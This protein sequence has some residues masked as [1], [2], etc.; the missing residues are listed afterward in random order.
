ME[1]NVGLLLKK[2][3]QTIKKQMDKNL[4]DLDLTSAQASVLIYLCNNKD[5][6]INQRN[7]EKEFNLTNPTVN[8]ILNRLESKDFIKRVTSNIDARNKEIHLTEKSLLLDKKMQE[9]SNYINKKLKQDINDEEL[10][11]F[12]DVIIKMLANI[13]EE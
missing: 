8:G 6:I 4:E 5:I 7:I 3:M 9:K 2:I 1:E 10:K 12:N 13:E 11:I